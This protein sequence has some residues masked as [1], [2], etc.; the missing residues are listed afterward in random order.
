MG[1]WLRFF[2]LEEEGLPRGCVEPGLRAV[3]L[4]YPGPWAR[5]LISIAKY[6]GIGYVEIAGAEMEGEA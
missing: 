6:P 2:L 5:K 3:A 4:V 1:D